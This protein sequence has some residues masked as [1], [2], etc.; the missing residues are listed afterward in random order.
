MAARSPVRALFD[1]DCT[2]L[3]GDSEVLWSH[4]LFERGIVDAEFDARSPRFTGITK[5]GGWTS[6]L[7]SGTCSG[8]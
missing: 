8:P 5:P 2:L 3:D 6:M 1:F 4:S 7:T